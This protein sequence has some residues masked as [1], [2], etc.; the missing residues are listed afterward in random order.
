MSISVLILTLNESV[1]LGGC[2][3]S[4]AWCDDV[5]VLDS[6]SSDDTVQ[7]ARARGARVVERAFDNYAAQRTYGL[8]EIDYKHAWILMLDADERATPELRDEMRRAVT[9]ADGHVALFL[10]RRRDYLFG[11]W[12][13]RSSGYPT[14]FGRLIRRGRVRVERPINEEYHADG[15][16]LQLRHHLDHYPF[17][18]GFGA[19]ILKHERYASMEATLKLERRG[20]R[21]SWRA[22]LSGDPIARR[23]AHKSLLYL[24]PGRPLVVFL[25]LYV[26]RGGFMEGSAGFTFCRLRAWY[27]FLIDCKYRELVRRE[28]G[29]PV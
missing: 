23:K 19:W 8:N 14:W 29:L 28:W 3:D 13:R 2:L 12:I 10:M 27:E 16:T 18:K 25:A 22:A 11:R 7:I 5:V 6:L 20:E 17:N 4:I 21:V 15:T 1:N 24:L 9:Q 26:L